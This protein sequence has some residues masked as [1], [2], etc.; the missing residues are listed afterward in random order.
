[1][2]KYLRQI[3]FTCLV[4]LFIICAGATTAD[5]Q[6]TAQQ[7]QGGDSIDT[8]VEIQ[9]NQNYEAIVPLAE[10]NGKFY[11]VSWYKFTLPEY[12]HNFALAT[13]QEDQYVS[14]CTQERDWK[15]SFDNSN[16][17]GVTINGQYTQYYEANTGNT[18]Y[19]NVSS[20]SPETHQFSITPI[21]NPSVDDDVQLE[22]NKEYS[23]T[24]YHYSLQSVYS[25]VAPYTGKYRLYCSYEGNLE[26][27][28]YEIHYYTGQEV[29][30]ERFYEDGSSE[31]NLKAGV[32]YILNLTCS[33]KDHQ[34]Q[35]VTMHIFLSSQPV[36]SITI[37]D[38]NISLKKQE[39]YKLKPEVFPEKA[40]DT[41][42][43]YSSSNKQVAL[44]N[45][46]GCI[47]AVGP[48]SATITIDSNDGSGV[49]AK[50][51]VTVSSVKVT[52]LDLSKNKLI[53]D[54]KGSYK[55]KAT[56]YPTRADNRSVTFKSSNRKIVT[57]DKKTGKITPKKPGTAIITCTTNDGSKIT[58]KCK[59]I[60]KPVKYKKVKVG[61]FNR[62]YGHVY[63]TP[64]N[65]NKTYILWNRDAY[66]WTCK[67]VYMYDTK[68]IDG[69]WTTKISKTVPKY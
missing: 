35:P 62:C 12:A 56:T 44:V 4:C 23:E 32:K 15:D 16:R 59:V 34:S 10:E 64:E 13:P 5:A 47:T 54:K 36:E 52:R 39:Q 6:T 17:Y 25:F 24:F 63:F 69:E 2:K 9:F 43:K 19:V 27:S 68:K 41:S 7:L 26:Y 57:V 60:V 42:V 66:N 33:P 55:I 31:I 14:I 1:M 8:A 21:V 11:G 38:S 50:C 30:K 53:I 51:K 37:E 18:Y 20:D 61:D 48:G 67:Y 65:S 45:E 29:S 22:L 3:I 40:V 58:K 49:Q 28:G 46:D